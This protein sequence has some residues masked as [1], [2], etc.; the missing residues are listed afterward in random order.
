MESES[1]WSNSEEGGG[2][3]KS[4]GALESLL[5]SFLESILDLLVLCLSLEGLLLSSS[6]AMD[7]A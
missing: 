3:D 7:R 4:S 6:G 1:L 2:G 5:E